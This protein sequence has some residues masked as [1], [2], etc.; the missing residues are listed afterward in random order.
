[1]PDMIP[2]PDW[3]LLKLMGSYPDAQ[4]LP[5]RLGDLTQVWGCS[6]MTAKRQLARLSDA[7]VLSY[8]AGRGRGH[9]SRLTLHASTEA[10]VRAT[11]KQLISRR[12]LGDLARL[13]RLPFPTTW[14]FPP[15]AQALFGLSR[16]EVGLDRLRTRILRPLLPLHPV[17]TNNAVEAHLVRQ[18]FDPLV[19]F[20][21]QTHTL[22]PGLSHHWSHQGFTAWTFH[23]RKGVL[24]HDGQPFTSGDVVATFEALGREA[25]WCLPGLRAVQASGPFRVEFTLDR[26]DRFFPHR[27]S[28]NTALIR[29]AHH[30]KAD[31]PI[32][33]GA[34]HW[35]A[36]AEGIRL[37]AFSEHF[38][39]RPLIDEVEI[40]HMAPACL[41]PF[42]AW[43]VPGLAPS[44][45]PELVKEYVAPG[46]QYLIWDAQ[47]ELAQDAQLRAALFELLDIPTFA[48]D[49]PAIGT[50]HPASAFSPERSAVRGMA[51]KS[52]Q[53][54]REVLAGAS[55]GRPVRLAAVDRWDARL[56]ADWLVGRAAAL[57][58]L[59]EV[60]LFHLSDP[61]WMRDADVCLLAEAGSADE[62]MA[63]WHAFHAPDLPFQRCLPPHL[64]QEVQ[65]LLDGFRLA[66]S[67][68]QRE[69]LIAQVEE[70]VTATHWVILTVHRVVQRRHHPQ[71]RDVLPDQFGRINYKRFWLDRPALDD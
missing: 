14:T 27:L 35:T 51:P 30:L 40:Y 43:E 2:F 22:Q 68:Q 47:S 57:G 17:Y 33:T 26:P 52:L 10:T 7:G 41:S 62:Q 25:P 61:D 36:L 58:L 29:P 3:Y 38:R 56:L 46:V 1:M 65:H 8:R 5:V 59:L 42:V 49:C 31:P 53:R 55:P 66:E 23:L 71:M 37:T 19:D 16:S 60:R 15:A 20:C 34:F 39:E 67:E 9:L 64:I 45:D 63:F 28:D 32:G 21:A 69:E 18:V 4:E 70:R 54:A 44:Q 48:V 50:V 11:V 12:Q 24:F 6:P 13:S